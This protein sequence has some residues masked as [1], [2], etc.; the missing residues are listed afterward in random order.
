MLR[1]R[2]LVIYRRKLS[3]GLLHIVYKICNQVRR[4]LTS[5]DLFMNS[6]NNN[7][8]SPHHLT[9]ITK[10]LVQHVK[11]KYITWHKSHSRLAF[12]VLNISDYIKY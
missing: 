2:V 8:A 9:L 7:E 6:L 3:N 1:T 12:V 11:Y 4:Y 10:F 5:H